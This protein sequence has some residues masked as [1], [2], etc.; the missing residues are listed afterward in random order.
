MCR[1]SRL[2]A[3]LGVLADPNFSM[4]QTP[5]NYLRSYRRRSGLSQAEMAFLLGC[6]SKAK[7]SRY[8]QHARRPSLESVFIYEVVFGAHAQELFRGVFEK[9]EKE[10]RKRAQM[11]AERLRQAKPDDTIARKLSILDAIVSAP[12][13]KSDDYP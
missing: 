10:T 2:S 13:S 11:L 8:E 7:V 5:Q 12:S 6:R 9:V 1:P 4:S 3:W